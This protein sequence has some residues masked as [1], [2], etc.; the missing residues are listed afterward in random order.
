MVKLLLIS[1][2]KVR[3]ICENLDKKNTNNKMG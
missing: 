1:P 3:N 2:K